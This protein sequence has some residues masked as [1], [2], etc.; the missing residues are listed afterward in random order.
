[1]TSLGET[2]VHS[3]PN[4]E[5][6]SEE[7]HRQNFLQNSLQYVG[8]L[9]ARTALSL[10]LAVTG[11]AAV[12]AVAE[13]TDPHPPAAVADTGGYPDWEAPCVHVGDPNFGETSGSG[14]WCDNYDWGYYTKDRY[15]NVTSVSTNSSRGYGYRNCTDWVAWRIPQL[16]Q[17]DVPG[18]WGDGGK[19]DNAAIAASKTV[20]TTPEPGDIAVWDPLTP[21]GYGHVAVVE[22]VNSDGSVNISEYNK[23]QDG[24]YGTRSNVTG[25]S[26]FIDLNGTG[27]GI[28]G[29]DLG[30]GGNPA[31]ADT[32]Q[33]GI[34]D[35]QDQ[36]PAVPGIPA[37]QGCPPKDI[38]R[39]GIADLVVI[40]TAN[41]GSGVTEAHE[42]TGGSAYASWFGHQATA[43]GYLSSTQ[44]PLM[45]DV[46]ADHRPDLVVVDTANT[47]SGKVEVHAM[48]GANGFATWVEHAITVLDP[49]DATQKYA[50]ADLNDDNRADLLIINTANT[51]SGKVEVHA[52]DAAT[53]YS[54]WIGHWITPADYLDLN[55]QQVLV[56]DANGDK[57][58][59]VLIVDTANTAS[60]KVEVHELNGANGFSAW[61]GHWIT[62]ANYLGATQRLAVGDANADKIAD[63][64]VINTDGAHNGSGKVEV[65]PLS[66]AT[67]FS[68]WL[69]HHIVA[70]L[71]SIDTAQRALV[72]G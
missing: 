24:N 60:G 1:M 45:G 30:G 35:P 68:A 70:P 19:W 71:S 39:D 61:Q 23:K 2:L 57:R 18:G 53:H 26:H 40:D 58:P 69:G 64:F 46:N 9:A 59:D 22:S 55:T 54:A 5:I 33:D 38:D 36:C 20:D 65:H 17:R 3:V 28:N 47:G 29:E 43:A 66:G 41:T 13:M 50:L 34:I 37:L 25:V 11:G 52:L 6:L 44:L 10:S 49:T 42:L 56:G 27:K 16:V 72:A 51:G 14:K 8:R 48:D 62:P 63:L 32:D 21:G 7:A 31:P 4:A 67:H 15:G 12:G